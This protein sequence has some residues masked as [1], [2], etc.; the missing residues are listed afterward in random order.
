MINKVNLRRARLL[1]HGRIDGKRAQKDWLVLGWVTVFGFNSRCGTSIS[2]CNQPP[3]ST[4]PGYPFVGRRN[5]YQPKGGDALQL[6]SKGRYGSCV[7]GSNSTRLSISSS[8]YGVKTCDPLVT[9]GPYLSALEIRV[10]IIKCYRNWSVYFYMSLTSHWH[11]HNS[12]HNRFHEAR[13]AE[14]SLYQFKQTVPVSY[15]HL[16]LPTIYSV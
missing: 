1:V 13:L 7:R 5:E 12:R 2:V 14:T 10:G 16:T 9:H 6:G 4:Q 3:R 11:K 15:T 8:F